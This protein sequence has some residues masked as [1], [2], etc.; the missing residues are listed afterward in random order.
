MSDV[1]WMAQANCVG[2]D[3]EMF[4][5]GR[6]A[7]PA[8][9]AREACASCPV[10]AECLEYA[11]AEDLYGYW[12]G[13]GGTKRMR[14]LKPKPD[15]TICVNGHKWTDETLYVDPNTGRRRCR[16]CRKASSKAYNERQPRNVA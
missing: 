8:P 1:A 15:P 14:V 4:F 12:G 9:E 16:E 7:H 3:T 13:T 2:M 5:P 10:K 11:I 6:G